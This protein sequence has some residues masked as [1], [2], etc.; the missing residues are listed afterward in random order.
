MGFLK[1]K[2]EMPPPLP[3]VSEMPEAPSMDDPSV[4]EAGEE[5]KKKNKKKKGRKST[6]LTGL[7]GDLT[8]AELN[9][10]TLLGDKI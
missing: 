2:I 6:I 1:P 4:D 7:S 5:A 9:N 3:P 10:P 8:P